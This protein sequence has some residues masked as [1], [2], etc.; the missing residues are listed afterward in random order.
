M[1]VDAAGDL[2]KEALALL[3]GLALLE[4]ALLP[5]RYAAMTAPRWV[6]FA[7]S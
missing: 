2:V 7:S 3:L 4:L 6:A 5:M 1:A